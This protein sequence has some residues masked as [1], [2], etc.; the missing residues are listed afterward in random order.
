MSKEL[1]Y[2]QFEPAQYLTKDVSFC[3]LSAQGLFINIC[4]HYWQRDCEL[5]KT[6]FLKRF[7]YLEEFNELVKEGAIDLEGDKII[8]KF[9]DSQRQKAIGLSKVNSLNGSKGGRPKKDKNRKETEKKPTALISK[10][11]PKGI[12]EDNIKEEEIKLEN[13]NNIEY[14]KKVFLDSLSE[15]KLEYG[16]KLIADFFSYWSEMN[17]AKTKMKFELEKT[18]ENKRRLNT[19]RLNNFNG[20]AI[21]KEKL[22]RFVA[23]DYEA[24]VRWE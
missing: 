19:W 15:Y 1:P 12:K 5:T 10:S 16:D 18:F 13:K 3:S 23:P 9:L 14:R 11:E 24:F 8:I 17:Q 2:F 21:D 22:K 7:N 20:T 4:A 6:Q